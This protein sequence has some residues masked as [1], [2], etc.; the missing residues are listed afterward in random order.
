MRHHTTHKDKESK[1][2]IKQAMLARDR[3]MRTRD[4]EEQP[5]AFLKILMGFIKREKKENRQ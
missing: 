2:R 3:K 4:L 5:D 1:Q